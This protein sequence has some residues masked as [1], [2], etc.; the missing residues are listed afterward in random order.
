ML[1]KLVVNIGKNE[2]LTPYHALK[3]IL[4]VTVT[5][6]MKIRGKKEENRA[7][8][9]EGGVPIMAQQ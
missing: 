9:R 8:K 4:I 5:R 2:L 1:E 6:T 3:S 7:K